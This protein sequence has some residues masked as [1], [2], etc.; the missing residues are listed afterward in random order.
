M[1]LCKMY[2]VIENIVCREK[3]YRKGSS[4][5]LLRKN[6]ALAPKTI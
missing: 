6:I 3:L 2:F 1:R 4:E 5:C